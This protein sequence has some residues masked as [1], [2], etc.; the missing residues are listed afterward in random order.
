MS[1]PTRGDRKMK[2]EYTTLKL[3]TSGLMGGKFDAAELN[4]QM[5]HLGRIGWEL[6]AAFDTNW[7][8][9]QSRDVVVLLKRP[10]E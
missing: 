1:A 5:N 6:A 4:Q 10:I 8:N 2:W 7:V 9:G 3:E